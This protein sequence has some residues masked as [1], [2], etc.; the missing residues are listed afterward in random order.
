V[1]WLRPIPPARVPA[2]TAEF[3]LQEVVIR[4]PRGG[5]QPVADAPQGRGAAAV[6]SLEVRDA[7]VRFFGFDRDPEQADVSVQAV[8][9]LPEL[10]TLLRH[11]RL[12][13]FEK[14]KLEVNATGGQVDARLQ[15]GFPMIHDLPIEALQIRASGK[16][17]DGRI[18]N[19]LAGLD[20]DRANLDVAVTTEGLKVGGQGTMVEAPLRLAVEMDF[21]GG[22]PTQVVERITAT[23]PR[24]DARQLAALGLDTGGVIESG[25]VAV[26]AR[27]EKRRG[28]Q[29]QVTL[30]ADLAAARLGME[31]V[32]WAKPVGAPGT[33][34]AVMR[35]DGPVATG[36][37]G[38]RV[39][40]AEVLLRGTARF[41]PGVRLQQVSI[42]EG[43][44]AG[45]RF[46]GTVTRPAQEGGPWAVALRG[47]LLDLRQIL[48]PGPEPARPPP[49]APDPRARELPFALDLR[50]DRVALGGQGELQA[51]TATGRT[52]SRG[53]LR[54]AQAS[55]RTPAPPGGG[56]GSM[57]FTLIPRGQERHVRLVAEDGGALLAALD[58]TRSI[59]GGRLVVNAVYPEARPGAPLAGTAELDQFVVRD[60]PGLGKLLQAM[61]LYGVV[62][63]LQGG[64][65]LTFMRLVA[66]FTLTREALTLSDARAFSASLGLTAKGRLWRERKTV[67]LEGTV[68]P[69]YF[70]N[71]LLG[72]IPILGRLFSPER[73]G[74]VF[75]AT[76][77][78]QGPLADPTV[79]VNPLAALT[80][81]FLRGLFG[82]AEGAGAQRQGAP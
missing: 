26:E 33:A 59:R 9:G 44:F 77:R 42:T 68:V 4:A 28:G 54:E 80:P 52:D 27:S 81:G 22:P 13:L 63:A 70:F 49:R 36:L 72:N 20:L 57:S 40:A 51:V 56:G 64:G 66:P 3:S 48:G 38:I 30:R 24:A 29:G 8:G 23:V 75:A 5:R 74:G 41:A 45:S 50:F 43:S 31:G 69:A 79:S 46:T 17:T 65:G 78:L 71:Q 15:I 61:T 37:D 82:L 19:A 60:A 7:T 12:K 39:E 73:G 6:P 11:P 25:T 47:P 2:A 67:E 14:R 58:L 21:R 55:G 53:V 1:H 18:A 32:G 76:Y 16:V 34:E 62:E 10:F 35:L